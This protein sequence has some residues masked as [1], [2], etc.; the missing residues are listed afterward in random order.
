MNKPR[1][2]FSM[3]KKDYDNLFKIIIIGDSGVGKSSLLLRFA[4]DDFTE[5]YISTIGVDFRFRT[6]KVDQ[7]TVKLQIWDTAGQERF[8][9]ITSAYYRG[10][11]GIVLCYDVTEVNSFDHVK[12]WLTEVQRYAPEKAIKLLVGTKADKVDRKVTTA[13][14]QA[15]ATALNIPFL[16]TSAFDASNVELTFRTI[17]RTLLLKN[18]RSSSSSSSNN[19]GD[20]ASSDKTT[21]ESETEEAGSSSGLRNGLYQLSNNAKTGQSHCC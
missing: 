5:N 15:F 19:N 2:F 14:G 16:E 11:D 6:L 3:A 4:D 7:T 10:A 12:D 8:R 13:Q 1:E 9:T 21:S 17:T 20:A 18:S